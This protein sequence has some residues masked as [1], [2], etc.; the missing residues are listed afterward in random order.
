MC[1]LGLPD[2][3]QRAM[4]WYF[5][6]LCVVSVVVCRRSWPPLFWGWQVVVCVL[7]WGCVFLFYT[8]YHGGP[9]SRNCGAEN[10]GEI[11]RPKL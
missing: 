11:N 10:R 8:I 7:L 9:R 3:R 2:E 5:L 6:R 4:G 1:L